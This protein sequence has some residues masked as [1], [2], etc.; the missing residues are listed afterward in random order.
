MI[1]HPLLRIIL[2]FVSI[3]NFLCFTKV[4]KIRDTSFNYHGLYDDLQL[5]TSL[6]ASCLW[7]QPLH[8]LIFL[9]SEPTD[10]CNTIYV[11]VVFSLFVLFK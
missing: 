10:M 3:H 2:I 7:S 1:A 11:E 6:G 9:P 8:K 5:N 4:Q